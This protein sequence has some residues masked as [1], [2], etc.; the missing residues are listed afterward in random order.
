MRIYTVQD[1]TASFYLPPFTAQTDD[2][3]KR[4]FIGSL[5]DSFAFRTDFSLFYIGDFNDELGEITKPSHILVLRGSS[6]SE[7]LDPRP[8]PL[9]QNAKELT[10]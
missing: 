7:M 8:R 9:Q 1:T 2:Q 3:A 5:G 10:Q 6:I 4:M